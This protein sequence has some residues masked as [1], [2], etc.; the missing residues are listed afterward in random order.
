MEEK[1]CILFFEETIDSL[2]EGFDDSTGVTSRRTTPSEGLPTPPN[3]ALNP[4]LDV[5]PSLIE[6]DI[7][8]L[9]HSPPNY[10]VPGTSS[11]FL[12]MNSGSV[13]ESSH[14]THNIKELCTK[15]YK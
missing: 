3:P 8:D 1:E 13:N 6:N 2:G 7:I 4:A 10:T 14:F 5:S 9:V 15:R 12:Q 11:N